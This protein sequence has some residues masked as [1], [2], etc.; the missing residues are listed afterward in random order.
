MGDLGQNEP[1][2]SSNWPAIDRG[3]TVNETTSFGAAECRDLVTDGTRSCATVLVGRSELS[4]EGLARVLEKTY[5]RVVASAL[6][7]DHLTPS[8]VQQHE[9][10]LLILDAGQDVEMAKRQVQLFKQLHA[11]AHIAVVTGAIRLADTASLFQAGANACFAEGATTEVFLKSLEL[12][13]LGET[14]VPSSLLAS[15]PRHEEAPSREPAAGSSLDLSHQEDRILS[16]L[17]D[18]HPNKVIARKLGIADATVKVHIKNIFCKIGVANRTQAA[19]W[20]MSRSS[21]RCPADNCP[22]APVVPTDEAAPAPVTS[23]IRDETPRDLPLVTSGSLGDGIVEAPIAP[24]KVDERNA[25]SEH[26][27]VP[28]WRVLPSE[29]RI[30]EEQERR[31]EF[32]A[33]TRRL[34]ELREAREKLPEPPRAVV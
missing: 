27:F 26:A 33:K 2:G 24:S 19:M 31:D 25:T 18:G 10:V 17:I 7:V 3:R 8:D 28:R 23:L 34:R 32:I 30:A 6:S 14:L 20:A 16:S 12:V 21:P 22:P 4:R 9:A 13:V 11:T 15:A 5:F 1:E 29:R